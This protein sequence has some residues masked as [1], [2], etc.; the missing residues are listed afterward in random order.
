MIWY[1]SNRVLIR[2]SENNFRIPDV[3]ACCKII[4]VFQLIAKSDVG[5]LMTCDKRFNVSLRVI[6]T[7]SAISRVIIRQILS[8]LLCRE[9]N[10][11]DQSDIVRII[12]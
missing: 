12:L 1:S 10:I 11:I 3:I 2:G 5:K 7:S 6:H 4:I 9:K 8:I